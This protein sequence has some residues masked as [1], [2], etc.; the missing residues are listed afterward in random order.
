MVTGLWAGKHQDNPKVKYIMNIIVQG[1][2]DKVCNKSMLNRIDMAG[3]V[4]K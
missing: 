1:S 4:R 3:D 2:M